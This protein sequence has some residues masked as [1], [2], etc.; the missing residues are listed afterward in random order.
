MEHEDAKQR[1]RAT[2]PC[3]RTLNLTG[4]LTTSATQGANVPTE[5]AIQ[6]FFLDLTRKA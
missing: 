4:N 6:A 3:R 1:L 2:F 5:N